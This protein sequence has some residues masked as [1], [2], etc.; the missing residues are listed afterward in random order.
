LRAGIA[1]GALLLQKSSLGQEEGQ[2]KQ[3]DKLEGDFELH[4]VFLSNLL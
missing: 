3:D 4:F 1:A 2:G